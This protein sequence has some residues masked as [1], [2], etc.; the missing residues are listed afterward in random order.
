MATVN[1]VFIERVGVLLTLWMC[2]SVC[3]CVCVVADLGHMT[4][5]SGQLCEGCR[6]NLIKL[7]IH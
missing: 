4:S 2:S 5:D 7:F 6:V 3:V 1:R